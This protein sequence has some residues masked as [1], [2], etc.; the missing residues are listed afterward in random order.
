MSKNLNAQHLKNHLKKG[1]KTYSVKKIKNSEIPNLIPDGDLKIFRKSIEN[2]LQNCAKKN[3]NEKLDFDGTIYTRKKVCIDTLSRILELIDSGLNFNELF[4]KTKNEMVW[5]KSTGDALTHDV[6]F[7]GY[8]FPSM[9]ATLT[10]TTENLYAFYGKPEDLVQVSIGGKNTW[11]KK[12]ADGTLSLYPTREEI[13]SKGALLGKGLEL[14]FTKDLF[15]LFI[16]QV[17]GAGVLNI[18]NTDGSMTK[19]ILNYAAAN[20]RDYVSPRRVLMEK[21]VAPEFL[22]I[23]GMKKYFALHPEELVPTLNQSPSYVFFKETQT[24]AQGIDEILLSPGH[25]LAI[26]SNELPMGALAFV[27]T[28]RPTA[29]DSEKFETFSRFSIPQDV[30]GAIKTPGRVDFYWGED[31]YAEYAAGVMNQSGEIYFLVLK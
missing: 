12:N 3:Q 28:E 20:G 2:Q 29:I 1:T 23:P 27:K 21:G 26:D 13:D 31:K 17:Q 19:K 6:K 4:E 25:S 15:D 9:E 10:K 18:K 22:T 24:G 5:Y 7:T 14:G 11:R 30:G 8:Y 16:F